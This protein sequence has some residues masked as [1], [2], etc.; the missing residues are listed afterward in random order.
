MALLEWLLNKIFDLNPDPFET[1]NA[2]ILRLTKLLSSLGFCEEND[3]TFVEGSTTETKPQ[4]FLFYNLSQYAKISSEFTANGLEEKVRSCC[5]FLD[6]LG[7]HRGAS[8]IFASDVNFLPLDVRRDL[9]SNIISK[10]QLEEMLNSI[11][12][13]MHD[14]KLKLENISSC[15][16]SSC[17]CENTNLLKDNINNLTTLIKD[18]YALMDQFNSKFTITLEPWS[19]KT[20]PRTLGIEEL[21]RKLSTHSH[22]LLNILSSLDSIEKDHYQ[23]IRLSFEL[24]ALTEKA[25]MFRL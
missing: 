20:S 11:R 6:A 16:Q 4:V 17:L 3:F 2:K 7:H 14:L 5:V 19:T 15:G 23:L 12:R 8:E 9:P 13:N 21:A 25:K 22:S 18:C 10:S 24:D 1:F